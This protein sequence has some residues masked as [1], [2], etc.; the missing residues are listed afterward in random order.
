MEKVQP[1]NVAC[2]PQLT[3]FPELDME[4]KMDDRA[5]VK[6]RR[7]LVKHLDQ[8][9]KLPTERFASDGSRNRVPIPTGVVCLAIQ[10][11]GEP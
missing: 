10:G 1:F 3:I 8:G 4:F 5:D 6:Y 11:E 9:G 7:K 2:T